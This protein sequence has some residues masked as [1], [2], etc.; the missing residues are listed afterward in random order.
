MGPAEAAAESHAV[1]V[2]EDDEDIRVLLTFNLRKAG[3][4]V[5]SVETIETA[6]AEIDAREPA[7][8]LVDRVLPDGD[9]LDI[10]RARDRPSVDGAAILVVSAKG[11]EADRIQALEAGADDFIGKPFSVRELVARVRVLATAI[12]NRR[13]AKRSS[14]DGV[15]IEWHD[16]V[17]ELN[18]RRLFVAGVARDIRPLELDVLVVLLKQPG[19]TVTRKELIDAVWDTGPRPSARSIDVY[20]RRL[21]ERL[22]QRG[23][24]L[25][26]VRGVG[27]RLRDA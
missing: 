7:V 21:R 22:G 18:R 15:R 1:V 16:V 9:G 3:F 4:E 14:G 10:L 5:G 27:Y 13:A 11:G 25:E 17:V 24:S 6:L 12:V 26:T 8:I 19:T 2:V 20:V 23:D